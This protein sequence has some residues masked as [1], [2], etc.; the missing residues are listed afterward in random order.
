MIKANAEVVFECAWEVCNKV[1]GIHTVVT[2]KARHM[3]DFYKNYFLIG[4]YFKGRSE[5]VFERK[6]PS[7]LLKELFYELSSEL[8]IKCHYG[9]WLIEGEPNVILLEFDSLKYKTNDLKKW[10]WDNFKIDSM[11]TGWDFEEPMLW[12]YAIGILIDKYKKKSNQENIIAHFHE[13]MTGFGLLYLKKENPSVKTI[14]T[15][16][17]TILGRSI[18]SSGRHLYSEL[19]NVNPDIE[20]KNYNI[21]GKFTAERAAAQNSHVFTTVSEITGKECKYLLGRE[22]DVLTLNGLDLDMFPTVEET[23]LLHIKN[24]R[25]L[26]EYITYHFFPYYEFDLSHNLSFCICGRPELKN[27]GVDVFIRALGKLNKELKEN[28]IRKRTVTVFIWL[29]YGEKDSKIELIENK[30]HFNHIQNTIRQDADKILNNVLYD[31]LEDE[32]FG[33][34]EIISK[35]FELRLKKDLTLFKKQGNPL[36]CSQ[37]IGDESKNQ[38]INMLSKEGLDNSRDNPVKVIFYPCYLDGNDSLLNLDIY[39]AM[40]GCHLTVF[41]SFYE[42]WGY[43]PLESA[44]LS[45]PTITTDLAGFGKFIKPKNDSKKGKEGIFVIDRYQKSD[46]ETVV[47]LFETMKHFCTLRHSERV[48]NKVNAKDLSFLADWKFLIENYIQ[49]H[50]LAL[51]R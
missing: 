33:N 48:Q 40:S 41:P 34:K 49:A 43:T 10:F 12:S 26:R 14:F 17:A 31:F 24:R 8:G 37:N 5:L 30:E 25:K 19:E 47:S 32:K 6:S 16:H 29:L 42:P 20:A 51:E 28:P 39:Q 13:W 45:V 7:E 9:K 50:N 2:S 36:I 11:N 1:G 38:V 4:P 21:V 46:E 23:A 18:A 27:K 44:A 15:T 35:K 3:L 22:P